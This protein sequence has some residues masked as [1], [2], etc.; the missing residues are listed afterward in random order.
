MSTPGFRFV[1]APSAL[2]GSPA[3]WAEDMLRAGELALLAD[4]G[5]TEAVSRLAHTLGLLSVPV[6]RSEAT[7]ELQRETVM[8]YAAALPL[9]WVG[10]AFGDHVMK[11]AQAR[12]PMTLLLD[13]DGELSEDERRRID[14]FVAILGRQSE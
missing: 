8:A 11:W 14:R 1:C 6:L 9:V 2:A 4:E 10:A 13:A 3:G 7:P 5:G 12:G